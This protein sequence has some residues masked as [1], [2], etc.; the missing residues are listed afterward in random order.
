MKF[1]IANHNL[2]F[3]EKMENFF[4]QKKKKLLLIENTGDKKF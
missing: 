3:I 2:S 1:V 4:R